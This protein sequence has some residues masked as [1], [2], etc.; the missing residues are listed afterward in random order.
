MEI[1]IT[2]KQLKYLANL[3]DEDTTGEQDD[4]LY[5]EL[6]KLW[7]TLDEESKVVLSE[8]E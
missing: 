5:L 3:V 8:Q 4:P 1:L 6:M 7:N 2:A